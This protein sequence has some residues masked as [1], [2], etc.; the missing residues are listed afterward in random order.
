[1]TIAFSPSWPTNKLAGGNKQKSANILKWLVAK[2]DGVF[3]TNLGEHVGGEKPKN[4]KIV[5]A[6]RGRGLDFRYA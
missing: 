5:P 6:E 4:R 2:W 3:D 1:M